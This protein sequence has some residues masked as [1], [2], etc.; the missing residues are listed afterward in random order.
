MQAAKFAVPTSASDAVSLT[1]WV[2]GTIFL[3]E[4]SF[5]SRAEI[6]AFIKNK[7]ALEGDDLEE[8]LDILL[9]EVGARKNLAPKRYPFAVA[10]GGIRY[11]HTDQ[12]IPYIFMLL[13]SISPLLRLES[14]QRQVESIFDNLVLAALKKYLGPGSN[15]VRFGTPV[16]GGRPTKFKRALEWLSKRLGIGRNTLAR[17]LKEPSSQKK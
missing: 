14:R 7:L 11:E 8:T 16:S 3:D 5:V 10:T 1:D 12:A 6:R 15:G 17:L 13:L 4:S 2:E 9:R